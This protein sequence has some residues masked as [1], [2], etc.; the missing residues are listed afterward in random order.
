MVLSQRKCKPSPG[1]ATTPNHAPFPALQYSVHSLFLAGI[2][3]RTA[4]E[5]RGLQ[6]PQTHLAPCSAVQRAEQP[7]SLRRHTTWE[8]VLSATSSY[9][10]DRLADSWSS[11]RCSN[12][13]SAPRGVLQSG[14][15]ISVA[16]FGSPVE[17]VCFGGIREVLMSVYT[18]RRIERA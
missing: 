10:C 2:S 4:A 15:T 3:S 16:R 14:T 18:V 1:A 9:C 12:P 11:N 6:T 5:A 7:E 17:Q 8:G 13:R